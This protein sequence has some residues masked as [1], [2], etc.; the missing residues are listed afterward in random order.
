MIEFPLDPALS[1][2]LIVSEMFNCSDEMAI[3]V[4]AISADVLKLFDWP[5]NENDDPT[6]S[7]KIEDLQD[8]NGDHLTLLNVYRKWIKANR[9]RKWCKE[10]RVQYAT[11]KNIDQ[12]VRQLRGIMRQQRVT[13]K[14]CGRDTSRVQAALASCFSQNAA[15]YVDKEAGYRWLG[16]DRQGRYGYVPL[17]VPKNSVIHRRL[18]AATPRPPSVVICQEVVEYCS[19]RTMHII[20]EVSADML[21][22]EVRSRLSSG[23]HWRMEDPTGVMNLSIPWHELYR[24]T[25]PSL[26]RVGT[27]ASYM[28]W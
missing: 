16:R 14:S 9:S 21:P 26:N 20:T 11:I 3:I 18:V 12:I 15:S 19:R 10:N 23:D 2:L 22:V 28:G 4:A 24:S 6:A 25:E 7:S 17:N 13:L 27:D 5:R 8:D 1:S